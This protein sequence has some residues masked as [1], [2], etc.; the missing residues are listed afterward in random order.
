MA[1]YN[2]KILK[3]FAKYQTAASAHYETTVTLFYPHTIEK[4]TPPKCFAGKIFR[5]VVT[6]LAVVTAKNNRRKNS[7]QKRSVAQ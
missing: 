2:D 3:T 6:Q 4:G 7:S 5:G 1:E